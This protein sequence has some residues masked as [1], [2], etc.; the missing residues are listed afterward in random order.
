MD[1]IQQRQPR[2]PYVLIGYS[3]GSMIAFETGKKLEAAG[4]AVGFMGS[5]NGPPHIKWRMVQIDWCELF[6]N[7]IYF[8]GFI[9]EEEAVERSCAYHKVSLPP[10]RLGAIH[11]LNSAPQRR[12]TPK[13]R[14]WIRSWRLLLRRS[15][16]NSTL[17]ARSWLA[18]QTS[19]RSYKVWLIITIRP[20][21]SS[22]STSSLPT[23]SWLSEGIKRCGCGSICGLGPTFLGMRFVSTT[24]PVL[25][26]P[27]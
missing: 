6:L 23:R 11:K 21:R 12:N 9:T 1:A 17:Q 4:H 25:T 7:L 5:L 20:E 10:F 27:C 19:L 24:A 15:S 2:G 18:G 16:R 13:R 3:F 26:T 14:F 8:L 22:E